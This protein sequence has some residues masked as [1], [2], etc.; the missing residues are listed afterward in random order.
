MIRT[1]MVEVEQGSEAWLEQRR[2]RI[3]ASKMG[4]VM[5]KPHT[6]RYRD[7]QAQIARELMGLE[8]FEDSGPW[9][10]HGKA[11]EPDARGAYEF[12][13][14]IELTNNVFFIHPEYDW[15]AASPDGVRI[16]TFDDP[17]EF[18][19]RAPHYCTHKD[20]TLKQCGG[21]GDPM[22]NY[23]KAVSDIVR[24]GKIEA[25]Y[26]PQVQMQI[27]VMGVD[28]V[29]YANYY[30]DEQ[31]RKRKLYVHEVARDQA[32]I[33]RMLE[34]AMEFMIECYQLAGKEQLL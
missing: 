17:V 25:Q 6:L 28:S 9:F 32:F 2:G 30:H 12:Q 24:T 1:K 11:M 16:E 33:D 8:E 13:K 19:C 29:K 26:R 18:K 3:T 27:E 31:R 15:L 14:G 20:G 22:R 10:E 34:R 21:C 7:Y 4:C 23:R 5:A